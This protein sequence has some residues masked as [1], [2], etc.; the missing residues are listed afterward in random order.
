LIEFWTKNI[1][2]IPNSIV[3]KHHSPVTPQGSVPTLITSSEASAPEATSTASA[4][5]TVAVPTATAA[6]ATSITETT[7]SASITVTIAVPTATAAEAATI[8]EATATTTSSTAET[9]LPSTRKIKS[10]RSAV[11]VLPIQF[12]RFL[13]DFCTLE[14]DMAETSRTAVLAY[15]DSD[16]GDASNLG[17][18]VSDAVLTS[19]EAHVADKDRVGLRVVAI[20]A[21]GSVWFVAREVNCNLA[22]SMRLPVLSVERLLGRSG[23]LVLNESN[24][25]GAAVLLDE[26]T[27]AHFAVLAENLGEHVFVDVVGER[28]N[29]D[30]FLLVSSVGSVIGVV[31]LVVRVGVVD[32]LFV[33]FV[34]DGGLVRVVGVHALALSF[35]L[36]VLF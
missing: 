1:N 28:L 15:G 20:A 23:A 32:H 8:A 34:L 35:H 26:L 22:T 19:V 30:F 4:T 6:E 29:E 14:F 21:L 3:D 27:F 25:S 24:S 12:K 36:V 2:H 7:T 13:C 17:E 18:E 16:A 10:H 33:L 11:K 9:G 5:V 31:G